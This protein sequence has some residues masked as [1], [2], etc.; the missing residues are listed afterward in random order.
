MLK[1][2]ATLYRKGF[3]YNEIFLS[4]EK[5]ML[6]IRPVTCEDLDA[7]TEIEAASFPPEEK[8]TR[9]SF[10]RRLA[11]FADC[12][13]VACDNGR[14][15]ALINGMVTNSR[16]IEDAM[17][18]DAELHEPAGAWQSIFGFCALPSVRGKGVAP[19]LMR[20]FLEKAE[21]DGR[22]GVILTCKEALI[23][24]YEQYGFVLRG[25]S[26]SEHGGAVWYDMERVFERGD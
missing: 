11:V 8:A 25:R 3:S 6:T 22:R 10:E 12:F 7:L 4:K 17:F 26:A 14:P 21:R 16:T 18:A 5:E 23:G 24:Y 15:V 20:A 2:K 9:E 13:L 1:E 19:A